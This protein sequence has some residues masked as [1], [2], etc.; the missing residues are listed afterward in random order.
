MAKT[1]GL[2]TVVQISTD[3][4]AYNTILDINEVSHP[5]SANNEDVSAFGDTFVERLQTIKDATYSLSGWYNNA[6]TT[7]QIAIRN[8]LIGDSALYVKVLYDGT[9]GYKQQVV[10]SSFEVSS[11]VDGV[12]EVSIELE[13]TGAVT[14]VP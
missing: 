2:S 13:G 1:K 6:D 4:S 14:A 7:G 8:A 11:S 3:D 5:L 12:V 9:N 10:V